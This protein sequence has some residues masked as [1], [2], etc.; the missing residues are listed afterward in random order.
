MIVVPATLENSMQRLQLE[1]DIL[2]AVQEVHL[3]DYL[4]ARTGF[5]PLDI[6]ELRSMLRDNMIFIPATVCIGLFLIWWLFRR[7]MAVVLGGISIGVVVG[8]TMVLYVITDQPF[9]LISSIV[10]TPA[11]RTNGGGT[12]CISTMHALFGAAR[13]DRVCT[14]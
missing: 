5:I 1:Q 11:V 14:H 10:A 4:T 7:W 13:K 3:E 12:W 6:A 2:S 9:T 8:S